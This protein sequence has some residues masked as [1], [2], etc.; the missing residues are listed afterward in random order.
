M[1]I[2]PCSVHFSR[3]HTEVYWH[4]FP[5]LFLVFPGH[6]TSRAGTTALGTLGSSVTIAHKAC[7]YCYS[8]ASFLNQHKSSLSE[9]LSTALSFWFPKSISCHPFPCPVGSASLSLIRN[10]LDTPF[11][12]YKES[13]RHF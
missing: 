6:L 1:N 11:Y 9:I 10:N 4:C 3:S 8:F 13:F 12:S 2:L 7:W 5:F